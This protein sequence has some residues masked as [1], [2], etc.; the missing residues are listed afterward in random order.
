LND[1]ILLKKD[2]YYGSRADVWSVGVVMYYFLTGV[3][4]FDKNTGKFNKNN[5]TI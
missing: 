1:Q 3:L 5:S 2:G 4:P